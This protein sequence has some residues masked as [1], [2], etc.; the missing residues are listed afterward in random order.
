MFARLCIKIEKKFNT[1]SLNNALGIQ[2]RL[3]GRL[4]PLQCTRIKKMHVDIKNY[5]LK[6]S[7]GCASCYM[8]VVHSERNI[9]LQNFTSSAYYT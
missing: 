8:T 4:D 1:T 3:H 6:G 7:H 5:P 9:F 2:K